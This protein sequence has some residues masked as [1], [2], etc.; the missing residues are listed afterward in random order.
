MDGC[1]ANQKNYC[2]VYGRGN[3][4]SCSMYSPSSEAQF[5]KETANPKGK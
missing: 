4:I 1:M 2:R 5:L 3:C